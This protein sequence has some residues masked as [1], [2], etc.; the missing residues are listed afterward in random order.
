[1]KRLYLFCVAS[2]FFL[3]LSGSSCDNFSSDHTI[4][5]TWRNREIY[6]GNNVR[7]YN[8]SI[9][10]LSRYDT[11]N[12][13]ILN[14]YNLGYDV[15]TYVQLSDTVFNIVG[16]S[17]DVYIISG[18]GYFHPSSYTIDWEYSIVGNNIEDPVVEAH[19]EK[20]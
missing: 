1:M 6:S 14:M 7:T 4:D 20:P 15:E 16:C 10:S 12:Y 13:I 17:S 9:E 3:L 19:F 2:F 11:L 8:V 18:V 5:G